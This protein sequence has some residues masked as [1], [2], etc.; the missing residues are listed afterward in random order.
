MTNRTPGSHESQRIPFYDFA[1]EPLT[2]KTMP[3]ACM[4][5]TYA[6]KHPAK[7]FIA[8]GGMK[9]TGNHTALVTDT[10]YPVFP[11]SPVVLSPFSMSSVVNSLVSSARRREGSMA[12][13]VASRYRYARTPLLP[14]LAFHDSR[15]AFNLAATLAASSPP[16]WNHGGQT[17]PP[18]TII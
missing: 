12:L 17:I 3:C 8:P 6:L 15:L 14:L 1:R 11:V 2:L 9:S 7:P 18:G 13:P 10:R 4:R 5:D 16:I